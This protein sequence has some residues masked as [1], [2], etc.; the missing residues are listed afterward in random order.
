MG[1]VPVRRDHNGRRPPCAQQAEHGAPR[2]PLRGG[3]RPGPRLGARTSRGVSAGDLPCNYAGGSIA[4]KY[5]VGV[6]YEEKPAYSYPIGWKPVQD[7]S[8]Q[9]LQ[10]EQELVTS[11]PAAVPP[12]FVLMMGDNR[13]GSYDGRAWGLVPR[14]DVIGRSEFIWLPIDRWRTTR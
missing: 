3:G 14:D 5:A 9:D 4:R 11:P 6:E 2:L 12:G 8:P 10:Y 1:H 13:N 7:L